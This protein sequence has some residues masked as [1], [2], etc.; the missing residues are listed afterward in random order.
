[1]DPVLKALK[2]HANLPKDFPG[3]WLIVS[4]VHWEATHNNAAMVAGGAGLEL[5]DETSQKLCDAFAVF[6]AEDNM[7]LH[8]CNANTWLLLCESQK[9]PQT[10]CLDKALQRSMHALLADLKGTP[11][12]LRFLTESQMFFNRQVQAGGIMPVNGVWVWPA[13]HRKF[14][15]SNFWPWRKKKA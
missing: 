3:K 4:P 6:L 12:W 8:Y 7:Q 13:A 15:G 14:I 10:Q 2:K 9:P 5:S 1:M 11:Y